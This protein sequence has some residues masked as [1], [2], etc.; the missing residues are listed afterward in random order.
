MLGLVSGIGV[1][2]RIEGSS[3]F[4]GGVLGMGH[5]LGLGGLSLQGWG[6]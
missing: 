4:L 5:G 6:G 3:Y 1:D 2:Y